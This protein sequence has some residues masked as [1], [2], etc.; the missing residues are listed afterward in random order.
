MNVKD[1]STVTSSLSITDEMLTRERS[2]EILKSEVFLEPILPESSYWAEM[3]V[4]KDNLIENDV[5]TIQDMGV[6]IKEDE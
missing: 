1:Q 5:E 6:T 3:D 2:V 4:A